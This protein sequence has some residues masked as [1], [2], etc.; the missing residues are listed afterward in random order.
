MFSRC[1]LATPPSAALLAA[2]L[3]AAGPAFADMISSEGMAPYEVCGLC[4]GLDGDSAMA[5]FPKLAGQ[6]A[7]Y[8]EKQLD[9]FRAGRRLDDGGQMQAIVSELAPADIPI[10]AAWFESQP[11]PEPAVAGDPQGAAL[12]ED[13]Q[14]GGCHGGTAPAGL[15]V[16]HIA[17]QHA[18]YIERQLRAFRGGG[19]DN[20]P[21]GVMRRVAKDLTDA[22]IAQLAAH[23]SSLPRR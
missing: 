13:L 17:A 4:H 9:D 11:P 21:D 12:F 18:P 10:V 23:V 2:A 16:P 7:A 8:V 14:C 6:R 22:Q 1:R 19:R 20:D 3:G 5:K 15:T